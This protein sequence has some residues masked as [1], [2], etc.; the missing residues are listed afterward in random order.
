M[1]AEDLALLIDGLRDAIAH[2]AHPKSRFFVGNVTAEDVAAIRAALTADEL[3]VVD[4]PKE[5][6]HG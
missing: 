3:A 4:F 2:R 5:L 1:I 6:A